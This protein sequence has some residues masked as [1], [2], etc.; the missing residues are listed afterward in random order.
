MEREWQGCASA[1][2]LVS[3]WSVF[4]H[5]VKSLCFVP[6]QKSSKLGSHRSIANEPWLVNMRLMNWSEITLQSLRRSPSTDQTVEGC[7]IG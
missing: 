6:R 2:T 7:V 3:H 4:T 1:V 5:T